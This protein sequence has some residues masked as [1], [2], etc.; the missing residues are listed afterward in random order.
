MEEK[1]FKGFLIVLGLDVHEENAREELRVLRD[2]LVK[3]TTDWEILNKNKDIYLLI[4]MAHFNVVSSTFFGD[5]GA[6]IDIEQ[7]KLVGLCGMRPTVKKIAQ[8]MNVIQAG[9]EEFVPTQNIQD[10]IHKIRAFD[11]L[12]EGFKALIS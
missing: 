4:N 5:I 8:R 12:D 10:N 6:T 9:N 11:S 3:F 7:I 1:Y 2:N